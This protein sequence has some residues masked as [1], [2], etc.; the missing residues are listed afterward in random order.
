MARIGALS[1]VVLWPVV[2][3]WPAQSAGISAEVRK[4]VAAEAE[5]A[6]SRL[7]PLYRHFHTHPEL[8]LHEEKTSQRLA[9]EL[10]KLNVTVTRRVGGY[11]IV[12]VLKNGDGPTVLVRT[13]MD[14]L[15]V[16][17]QTGAA[18]ASSVKTTD[19]K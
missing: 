18:Y 10:D 16:T 4:Q 5:K 13:D 9:D 12:G 19:D 17:E 6:S 14:A 3:V 15:P 2:A 11:G 8:S 1:M 7:E